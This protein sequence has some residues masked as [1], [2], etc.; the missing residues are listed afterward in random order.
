MACGCAGRMRRILHTLGYRQRDRVWR[1]GPE[2]PEFPDER[3]E[4][5]H[6]R[7]LLESMHGEYMR[8]RLSMFQRK[9]G[10]SR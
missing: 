3:V 6:F 10:G 1:R 7:V 2:D 5:E 9:I 8:A 4:E